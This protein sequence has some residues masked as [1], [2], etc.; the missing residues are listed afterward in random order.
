MSITAIEGIT[1]FL[2]LLQRECKLVQLVVVE[3][4]YKG[5]LKFI[6]NDKFYVHSNRRIGRSENIKIERSVKSKAMN[7]PTSLPLESFKHVKHVYRPK[8]RGFK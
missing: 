3:F 1:K 2:T 7:T 4:T 8:L 5:K 6:Y